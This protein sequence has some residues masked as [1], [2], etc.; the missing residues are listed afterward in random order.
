MSGRAVELGFLLAVV[1]ML[2]VAATAPFVVAAPEADAEEGFD[3][4]TDRAYD[5]PQVPEESTATVDGE[6]FESAQAAIDAAAPGETVVLEGRFDENLIINTSDVTVRAGEKAAAIDGGG[7]G[8]VVFVRGENVTLDGLWVRNSGYDAGAEH[9]GVYLAENATGAT[10]QD[11]YISEITFGVWVNGADE[12]RIADSRIEGR[13]DV[14][15]RTDRGNGI[16]LWETADSEIHN[17][18]I[19]DVRDGIYYSWAQGVVTTNNTM[20]DNRYGVHYMYSDDNRLENN[21]AVDNDVGYALMVSD[22]LTVVNN[23]A[24]RNDGTSGHGILLKD[25]ERSEVRGNVLMENSNGLYV[26]NTQHSSITENLLLR[27]DVGLHST[28][29]SEGQEVVANSFINNN[30]AVTTTTQELEIWNGTDRGNYW[31]GARAVDLDSDG[32]SE[33]RHRPAGLVEY[34]ETE[35]PQVA[36]FAASPA[37]DAVRLAESSFPVVE[38]PGIVDQRPLAE[39]HHDD[40]RKYADNS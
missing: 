1:G 17:N 4:D 32:I 8:S 39:P 30:D 29:E 16:N 13:E 2:V 22:E 23:T 12:V 35:N 31:S 34:L 14:E 33:V 27:N 38:A 10:L 7:E 21:L 25:I 9:A 18:E 15:R 26:Y 5:A 36:V 3:L 19:T 6:T 24:A 20:W 40:W 37:F 28:A 11:L